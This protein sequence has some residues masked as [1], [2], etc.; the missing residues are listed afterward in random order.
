MIQK[1][2]IGF[3]FSLYDAGS[4]YSSNYG[5]M[6]PSDFNTILGAFGT[7]DSGTVR[8]SVDRNENDVCL[9]S[10]SNFTIASLLVVATLD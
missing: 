5:P 10:S 2:K 7:A 8:V 4:G 3:F 1:N 6:L 9:Y